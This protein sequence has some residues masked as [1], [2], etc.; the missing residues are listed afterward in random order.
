M[1][2]LFL[3]RTELILKRAWEAV[4]L[5]HGKLDDKCPGPFDNEPE[6]PGETFDEKVDNE[7]R[8]LETD[9]GI[10]RKAL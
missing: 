3:S 4:L 6:P 8:R 5:A 10:S 7:A 1:V 9:A 2:D